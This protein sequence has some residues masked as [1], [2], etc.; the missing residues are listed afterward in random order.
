MLKILLVILVVWLAISLIGFIIKGLFWLGV[1]GLALFAVTSIYG[2]VK[3]QSL[4]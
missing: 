1:I 4:R 2:Y 3:R